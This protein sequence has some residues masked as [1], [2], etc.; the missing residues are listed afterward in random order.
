MARCFL[1]IQIPQE[2]T[3]QSSI[4]NWK[5]KVWTLSNKSIHI[6]NT[7]YMQNYSSPGDLEHR[8]LRNV[9]MAAAL[10]RPLNVYKHE[11]DTIVYRFIGLLFIKQIEP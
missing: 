5:P 7:K 8:W 1:H 6:T 3:N 11:F 2:R 9:K 4:L 10:I